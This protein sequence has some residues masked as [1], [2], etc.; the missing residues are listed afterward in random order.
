MMLSE[1]LKGVVFP[2]GNIDIKKLGDTIKWVV[3]DVLKDNNLESKD[4][5]K[6]VAVK[7]KKMFFAEYNKF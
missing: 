3:S 2:D 5:G 6:Y 7:V 1:C 4:I